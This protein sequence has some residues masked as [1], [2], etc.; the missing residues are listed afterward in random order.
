MI[1][2]R[3]NNAEKLY[4]R[5]KALSEYKGFAFGHQNAGHLGV[6]IKAHDG[7]ESDVKN[8]MGAHPM[9]IGV[10]TLSFSGYEGEFDDTVKDYD[11]SLSARVYRQV[12]GPS[13]SVRVA[14]GEEVMLYLTKDAAKIPVKKTANE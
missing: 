9:V 3:S 1:Y 14:M 4:A 7:S 13:D 10:D 11:D 5:L 12:P 2:T 8:I 6:S